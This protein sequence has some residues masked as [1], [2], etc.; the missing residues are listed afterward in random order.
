VC[1][2]AAAS[3][4]TSAATIAVGTA[5]LLRLRRA[6]E[7]PLAVIPLV[8]GAQQA[9]EGLLW[10]SLGTTRL[11]ISGSVLA[12]VFALFALVLWPVLSPV[13]VGLVEPNRRRRWGMIALAGVGVAV[14]AYGLN[15]MSTAPYRACVAS[16][17]LSYSNGHPYPNIAM[18][19]YIASTCLPPLLSSNRSLMVFGML[20]AASLIVSMFSYSVVFF[21]VWCFFAAMAS[22]A[23]LMFF[24][25][26]RHV[27][28]GKPTEFVAS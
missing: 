7:A 8:F 16:H 23:I 11:P 10:L 14:A 2:S 19:A 26:R 9:V 25:Y 12:G 27:D 22:V 15:A 1:F 5:S 17:S 13:A 3:F 4:A 20:V 18:A 28:L 21:S 24:S 6:S